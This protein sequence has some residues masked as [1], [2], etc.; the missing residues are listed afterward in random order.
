MVE[1]GGVGYV[2]SGFNQQGGP[3]GLSANTIQIAAHANILGVAVTV[4]DIR[5]HAQ[6][7]LVLDEGN[8]DGSLQTVVFVIAHSA[9]DITAELMLGRL[10]GIEN[11]ATGGVAT[12]EGALRAFQ[13]LDAGH[14]KLGYGT[15]PDRIGHFGKVADNSR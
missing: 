3:Y 14:I 15:A 10:R 5:R 4:V 12:K 13:H 2:R 7:Y 9:T 11:G 1:N 8:I 6:G